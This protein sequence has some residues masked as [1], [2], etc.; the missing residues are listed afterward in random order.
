MLRKR[1]HEE[2]KGGVYRSERSYGSFHRQIP[3]PEGAITEQ[4]KANFK[5]G[6]LEITMPAPPEQVRRGRRIDIT[7]ESH[8]DGL[9][10]TDRSSRFAQ[11]VNQNLQQAGLT[12]NL[13]DPQGQPAGRAGR[14]MARAGRVPYPQGHYSIQGVVLSQQ[15]ATRVARLNETSVNA[16]IALR[17]PAGRII[18]M[19]EVSGERFAG[20]NTTAATWAL[21]K[22]QAQNA[23]SQLYTA[24][25][26]S[27]H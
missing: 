23:S 26:G 20:Q 19:V 11:L 8:A 15:G 27:R 24:F 4:A 5:N 18:T 22:E 7:E 10:A 9:I 25:C 13:A 14:L 17:D 12:T 6:V 1:E 21:T 2:E 3:L 16:E